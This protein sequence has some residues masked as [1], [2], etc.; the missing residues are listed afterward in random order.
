MI[1]EKKKQQKNKTRWLESPELFEE[2]G[3]HQGAKQFFDWVGTPPKHPPG[4]ELK[5]KKN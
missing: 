2:E 4:G 1:K 5:K 3:Y